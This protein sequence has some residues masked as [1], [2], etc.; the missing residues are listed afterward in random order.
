LATPYLVGPLRDAFDAWLE[1]TL[2]RFLPPLTF[3]ELRRGVQALSALYVERRGE[4]RLAERAL[5]GAGKRAAFACFYAPLHFLTLHHALAALG[6]PQG[7]PPAR[8][9]DLGCGTGAAGAAVA[10]H[11]ERRPPL[12]AVDRSGFALGEARHTYRAFGVPARTRR[13]ALPAALPTVRAGDLWVLGWTVNECAPAV[14][15]ALRTR[16]GAAAEAGVALVVA[17]PLA[18]AATPWWRDWER[19]LAPAGVHARELKVRVELPLPLAK[20]DRAAGLDHRLLGARL[21]TK[22]SD[23]VV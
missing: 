10:A 6:W 5:D 2:A 19:A 18:T 17:E 14:E 4:G 21:L 9:A 7:T 16:V 15:E 8:I 11:F 12:L 1:A 20:L 22:G 3:P 13:G 23:R